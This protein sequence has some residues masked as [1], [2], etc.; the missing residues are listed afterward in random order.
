MCICDTTSLPL[1]HIQNN[2]FG[3][4]V[5]VN[6]LFAFLS[7]SASVSVYYFFAAFFLH[8]EATGRLLCVIFSFVHVPYICHED[9]EASRHRDMNLDVECLHDYVF[10]SLA[11]LD[12]DQQ[13]GFI[14]DWIDVCYLIANCR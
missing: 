3:I 6:F 14:V 1:H 11:R 5:L 13:E 10:L 9:Q 12:G 8:Q 4:V 2:S 7:Y